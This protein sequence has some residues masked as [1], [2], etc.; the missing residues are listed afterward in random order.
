MSAD[1]WFPSPEHGEPMPI[2][3]YESGYDVWLASP[4]G[5]AHSTGHVKWDANHKTTDADK[6]WDWSFADQ[7]LY[8]IP[9][10][11][12]H[13]KYMTSE[14]VAEP[15]IQHTDKI[16]YIGYDAGATSMLYGL[17][18]KEKELKELVRGAIL[19]APCVKMNILGGTM[20]YHYY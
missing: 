7:G 4:R 20:G 15:F 8:D 18:Y 13:I 12:K 1:S 2:Q 10:M 11:L 9:A 6:Y 3:L 17:S 19:L 16:V 14:E 5:S